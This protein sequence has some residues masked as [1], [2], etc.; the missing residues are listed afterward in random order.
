[1]TRSKS[2]I[3]VVVVQ[4]CFQK[5]LVYEPLSAGIREHG[6][7]TVQPELPTG[8]N[9][10]ISDF[11][12]KDLNDDTKVVQDVIRDL[13][14]EKGLKVVVVMHSYGGLVGSNAILQEWSLDKRQSLRLSGGV[15]HLFYFSAFI[16][17]VGQS[18]MGTYGKSPDNEEKVCC[19]APQS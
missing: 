16:M 3:A 1:M 18:V 2:D 14:E 10:E 7:L 9:S 15:A 8:T 12:K 17:G 11:T 19:D 4:G 13:V 6:Y 5:P